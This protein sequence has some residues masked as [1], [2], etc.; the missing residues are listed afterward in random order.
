MGDGADDARDMAEREWLEK[1]ANMPA[2]HAIEVYLGVMPM[3]KEPHVIGNQ[4]EAPF[5][6][7]P[8]IEERIRKIASDIDEGIT[9]NPAK[10]AFYVEPT[11]LDGVVD[12]LNE[13]ADDLS[14]WCRDHGMTP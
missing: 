8:G 7:E 3:P 6:A 11:A 4:G 14:R 5:D 13:I 12:T 1:T 9:C 10:T 2:H